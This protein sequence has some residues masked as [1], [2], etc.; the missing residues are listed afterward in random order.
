MMIRRTV[1]RHRIHM[2]HNRMPQVVALFV[3]LSVFASVPAHAQFGG[4][5]K[6]AAKKAAEAS[7]EKKVEKRVDPEN[8]ASRPKPFG[9]EF[10]E[11]SFDSLMRQLNTERAGAERREALLAEID[12]LNRKG[13]GLNHDADLAAYDRAVAANLE[14]RA[15]LGDAQVRDAPRATEQ[16]CPTP[17]EPVWHKEAMRVD[18]LRAQIRT[19]DSSAEDSVVGSNFFGLRERLHKWINLGG[20]K[21]EVVE[22]F[23][24]AESEMLRAHS[25]EIQ[26]LSRKRIG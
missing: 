14:C 23:G 12:S 5:L 2:S 25:A 4:L 17:R 24:V 15:L 8:S 10:T 21:G 6:K 16:K 9:Q 18:T 7:V 11:A 3:A 22:G 19:L 26:R 13:D 20:L 1:P